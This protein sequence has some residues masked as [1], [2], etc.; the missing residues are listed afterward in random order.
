MNRR[1]SDAG[2]ALL[3]LV[4]LSVCLV[5]HLSG[6]G[7]SFLS[8]DFVHAKLIADAQGRG[9]LSNWLIERLYLPLG[10]GNFAYRPVAF[11]SYALDWFLFGTSAW[12]WHLSNLLIHLLNAALVLI[13]ALR[14]GRRVQT[15]NEYFV[16]MAVAAMFLAIPFAGETTFWPVGRF[17]L[18]ACMFSL[19]FLILLTGMPAQAG[20]WSMASRKI[21][22]LACMLLALLSKESAMPMLAVGFALVF[23]LRLPDHYEAG[24]T[25]GAILST[26]MKEA[27]AR[28]WPVF[29]LAFVYFAWRYWIFG[30]PWKVY[31]SS[32]FPGPAEFLSRVTVLKH[33]FTYPWA[34]LAGF[35]WALIA[36]AAGTWLSGL[37]GAFKRAGTPVL[38]LT[39]VLFFC[40]I[41][42]L[43]APATSFPVAT[44]NG[45][46][47]RN[48]YFPWMLFSL[49]VGFA[50]AHHR[51]RFWILS[52]M[53]V[54]A[55]WG[56][57]RLVD[58]WQDS[59]AEMLRI[60]AAIPALAEN[61]S[62][63]QYVLLLLPD[64]VSAVPFAR[65]AQGS[66]VMPP[67]QP[68]SFLS[69]MAPMTA[70]QFAEWE[71]HL[72]TNI[73][74]ELKGGVV[75]D[76]R[77]FVGVYCWQPVQGQF[78]LLETMP[79]PNHAEDWEAKTM[80]EAT[81]AGCLLK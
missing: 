17:D 81:Q 38:L 28:Y 4:A 53:L 63:E 55:M 74:G 68:V 30:S 8:D 72:Q 29:V 23:A 34:G 64:H 61:I 58:L 16:A 10:S 27:L 59:A 18:L 37:P 35:W 2:P 22:M 24:T 5:A 76:R 39:L 79:H 31:P 48:L 1:L 54:I 62:D 60:T 46:G 3:F 77:R 66:I 70:L 19:L 44:V 73:I 9:E 75:F 49:F 52:I 65:N 12:G 33:V 47:I 43:F 14:L 26:A 45:E 32:Q 40:F 20:F 36:L 7:G 42:Y 11:A 51:F 13:L 21:T 80:A 57:W 78:H 50:L 15:G 41:G 67:V 71:K 56:Q 6:L 25:T 69:V